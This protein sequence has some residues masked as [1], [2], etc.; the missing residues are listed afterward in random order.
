MVRFS[1]KRSLAGLLTLGL[2]TVAPVAVHAQEVLCASAVNQLNAYAGEV[3]RVANYEYYQGIPMRC[4][5]NIMCQQTLLYQLNAW[6]QQNANNANNW[7]ATIIRECSQNTG[8]RTLGGNRGDDE[9]APEINTSRIE[10]IEIEDQDQT[11]R[12]RIPSSPNG[13]NPQ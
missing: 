6:Y 3:N 2:V 5:P 7:Y 4:G 12:I 8:P 9:Q 11:V 1:N 10:D 13:F